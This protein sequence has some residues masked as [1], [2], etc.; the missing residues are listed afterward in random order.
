MRTNAL[1]RR[2]ARPLASLA[3][4]R[5]F[6]APA[7]APAPAG[8]DF[9]AMRVTA[10]ASG[11]GPI[12]R[13]P[14]AR[15]VKQATTP[16]AL[17]H[18]LP[19]VRPPSYLIPHPVLGVD[20]A[21]LAFQAQKRRR[22]GTTIPTGPTIYADIARKMLLQN[23]H[24]PGQYTPV[25]VP[26]HTPGV[27]YDSRTHWP[28]GSEA[29]FLASRRAGQIEQASGGH[30]SGFHSRTDTGT[31]VEPDGTSTPITGPREVVNPGRHT[32][33]LGIEGI[34]A[35]LLSG[36]VT[37]DHPQKHAPK[38]SSRFLSYQVENQ[39]HDAAFDAFHG[40]LR[41]GTLPL[42]SGGRF[43]NA[44]HVVTDMGKPVGES[45][46]GVGQKTKKMVD[47]LFGPSTANVYSQT[48][49]P[50][51]TQ[52][53]RTVFNIDSNGRVIRGQHFPT[54]P[55]DAPTSHHGAAQ[56]GASTLFATT[57][58]KHSAPKADPDNL[59]FAWDKPK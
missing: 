2:T 49:A 51:S 21:R 54:S 11:S 56:A 39:A 7:A 43:H 8:H 14:F 48:T 45:V 24:M 18:F 1:L 13:N 42:T 22:L 30:A 26:G 35:R 37:G 53:V 40:A 23:P 5:A 32:A 6:A 34:T 16:Q 10:P 44:Y 38:T 27:L 15:L 31:I 12:Q 55:G 20:L 52:H 41:D 3:A 59:T 25:N 58:G 50:K 29:E 57:Y 17:S 4:A 33:S 46:Q 36:A 9:G 28:Q 47:S 19:M